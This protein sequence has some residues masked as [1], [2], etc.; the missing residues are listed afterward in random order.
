MGG[1][2]LTGNTLKKIIY[3][4]KMIY[5]IY[6]GRIYH[7][8]FTPINMKK[9]LRRFLFGLLAVYTVAPTHAREHTYSDVPLA[10][11]FVF[12]HQG[13][14]YAYGTH[15]DEGIEVLTSK[16]LKKWEVPGGK[17]SHIALHKNDSWGE[18][19]FWAPEVYQH[20]GTFYMYYSAEE[21]LCVATSQSPLGPFVQQE[22]KPMMQ[23]KS[24]DGSLF[25][26]D[27]GKA[28]FFFVRFNDGNNIWMAPMY[29]DR[30][31]FDTTAMR[32][33]IHVSQ[34]W[35]EVWPRVNE[36]PFILKENGIYYLTYS[37]NS[38]ESPHYGIGYATAQRID[39]PWEKYRGNPIFQSP[40]PLV[41]VGH[42]S[43]FKD[44]RGKLRIA[45]HAHHR[46]GQIH[47]RLMYIG[48]A[49]FKEA[50][51]EDRLIISTHYIAPYRK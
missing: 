9:F 15:S 12:Y 35:E 38:Y 45:F 14:Y 40:G 3:S 34:P 47:P 1:I 37:A 24:I 8:I 23:E 50:V 31:T 48:K 32:P 39:G 7:F 30:L 11:P 17:A 4:L 36:G 33:C 26:D 42:H 18:K 13:L 20:E 10:D 49:G 46:K 43:F 27:D 6:L 29:L 19:W 25:V 16:D 2:T 51:P 5:P 22:Q 28:Y 44:K 41:G 21:H